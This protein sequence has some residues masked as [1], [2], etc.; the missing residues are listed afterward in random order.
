MPILTIQA[1][2]KC[3][4]RPQKVILDAMLSATKVYN[5][6]LWHLRKEYLGTGKSDVSK[7]N[8]NRILKELPCQKEYYSLS[9]QAT[10]DEVIEA[11]KSF[12]ALRRAG[13]TQ[14]Q[15]PGFRRKTK[16]S[17][18][19]YYAGYGLSLAGNSLTLSFGN[20]RKD[21]VKTIEVRLEHRRVSYS[22]LVNILLTYDKKS[23]LT[24]HLVV[25]VQAQ[26]PKGHGLA[27]IDLGETH[28]MAALF[29]DTQ[30]QLYSGRKIKSIRRY[31]QKVRSRVQPP[32]EGMPKS[33]RYREIESKEKRQ[34]D[35]ILHI[36]TKDFVR[37]CR[38][39]GIQAI[40]IGDLTGIREKIDYG[41]KL[42]QRLHAW[43][44]AKITDMIRYKASRYSI[45]VIA[46]SEAYTSQTCHSCSLVSRANRKTRGEYH[47]S[48]G[49]HVHADINGAA[50]I[51]QKAFE[52][53]P[54]RS[55]GC[56]A[57][58]VVLSVRSNGHT[59]YKTASCQHV[60]HS[61]ARCSMVHSL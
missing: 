35:H 16:H 20:N 15:N 24:A 47:C 7:K 33:K 30:A 6:L 58:P 31:W 11:Y 36:M 34:V 45:S 56:V 48:C 40:A 18:L 53:S 10:R 49:W 50:N 42:N 29:S 5:G 12:F 14:Y 17:T 44:F 38:D 25:E 21:A 55:S 32:Q 57:Q 9:A 27:A 59:V 41:P 43:P 60:L 19:R 4:K 13:R 54:L 26:A 28:L 61:F 37:L 23:G 3:S 46:A 52:V 51:F 22:R 8:L 1:K 2:V 39:K